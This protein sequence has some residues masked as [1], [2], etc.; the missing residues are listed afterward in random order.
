MLS[1][2]NV[3]F[4]LGGFYSSDAPAEATHVAHIRSAELGRLFNAYWDNL[5]LSAKPLN[6][7]KRIDWDE[8]KAI[9]RRV[10]LKD[11]EYDAIVDKWKS[12]IKS[13]KRRTR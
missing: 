10:G 1:F 13:R 6:E 4:Y 12:E 7:G 8:L 5:W 2:D 3:D 11:D 9:A